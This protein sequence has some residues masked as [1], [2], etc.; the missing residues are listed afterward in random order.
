MAGGNFCYFRAGPAVF[1]RDGKDVESG[2]VLFHTTIEK[3][4]PRS[5]L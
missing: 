5:Y 4:V 3:G 2:G 1:K